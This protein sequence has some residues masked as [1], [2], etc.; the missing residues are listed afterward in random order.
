MQEGRKS[1]L[2]ERSETLCI[3]MRDR[4]FGS[5]H[6]GIRDKRC[7]SEKYSDRKSD[8]FRTVQRCFRFFNL[9]RRRYCA[10]SLCPLAQIG[11]IDRLD[12]FQTVPHRRWRQ[13]DRSRLHFG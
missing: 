5:V 10:S 8:P 7:G 9:G 11:G 12:R 3:G 2:I 1:E 4:D 13:N 6:S